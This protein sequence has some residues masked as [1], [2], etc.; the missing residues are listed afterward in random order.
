MRQ[1]LAL[2]ALVAAFVLPAAAQPV[3]ADQ[4]DRDI[5]EATRAQ[6]I[7][8]ALAALQ[9]AYVFPEVA[10]RMAEGVRTR[11]LA[12]GYRS[13][14]SA[15]EFAKA[16]TGHLQEVSHDKHLRV[17]YSAEPLPGTMREPAPEQVA[18]RTELMRSMNFGFAKAEVLPGNIGYLDMRVFAAGPEAE[19]AADAAMSR[20][21]DTDALIV[22]LRRNGGGSPAMVARVSSYLFERPTH[23]NSL[24]WREGGRTEEFWTTSEVAGKRFGER[25]PVFVLTSKRTFSGAE[26]FAYNLKALK[27]ATLVGETT[28]GGAHPGGPQRIDDHF[29]I[30][31]PAGRAINPVTK[32]N[33]EGTGVVPDVAVPADQALERALE[34][35]VK[36]ARHP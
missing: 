9:R 1:L 5:D 35:A 25:K 12:G 34:L 3:P 21:A 31:V 10:T 33:W 8:G 20:L 11:Q 27:R 23:L 7:E 22:D 15:S 28:A 24:Y 2:A 30:W 6:V 16:L 14:S 32:T 26:E 18:R 36:A 4:P 29:S 19:A 13:L 17:R